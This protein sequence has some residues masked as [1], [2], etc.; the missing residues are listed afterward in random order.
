MKKPALFLEQ[1][2]QDIVVD[3][4]AKRF[5]PTGKHLSIVES[6]EF[7]YCDLYFSRAKKQLLFEFS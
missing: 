3:S 4:F 2:F 1:D 7:A 6:T 5:S